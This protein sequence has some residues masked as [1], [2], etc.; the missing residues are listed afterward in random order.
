MVDPAPTAADVF[1]L[2][3]LLLSDTA[4]RA[5][6]RAQP[7]VFELGAAGSWRFDPRGRGQLFSPEPVKRRALGRVEADD[8]VLRVHTTEAVMVKLVRAEA[9]SLDDDDEA[10]FEG[11]VQHL[12]PLADALDQAKSVLGVRVA[13]RPS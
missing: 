5:D 12:L 2:L 10:W 6:R 13:R 1:A 8:G 3:E 9:F 11:D 4:I 7:V